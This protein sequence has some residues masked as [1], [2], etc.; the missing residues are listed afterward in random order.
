V[1][2]LTRPAAKPKWDELNSQNE[3]VDPEKVEMVAD[4]TEET[5]RTVS[6]GDDRS[7][8]RRHKGVSGS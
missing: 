5:T 3:E 8:Q 1:G 4:P 7:V 6:L 2:G